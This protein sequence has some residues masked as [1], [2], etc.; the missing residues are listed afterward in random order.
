M[1]IFIINVVYTVC[2]AAN[3]KQCILLQKRARQ[4]VS[5][6]SGRERELVARFLSPL[7]M[8]PL[9]S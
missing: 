7:P 8:I 9:T 1:I 5:V 4:T 6:G 2:L 3:A